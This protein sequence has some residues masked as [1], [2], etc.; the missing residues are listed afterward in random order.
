MVSASTP[1]V[2]QTLF[3]AVTVGVSNERLSDSVD[4]VT[5]RPMFKTGA[6]YEVVR[7]RVPGTSEAGV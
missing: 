7:A 1:G 2:A 6:K 3:V 5:T 4:G